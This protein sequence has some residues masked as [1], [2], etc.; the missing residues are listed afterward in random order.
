M[1]ADD[2]IVAEQLV[3]DAGIEGFRNLQRAGAHRPLT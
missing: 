3:A 2:E 1:N